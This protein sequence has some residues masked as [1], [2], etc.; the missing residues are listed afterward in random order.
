MHKLDF[1]ENGIKVVTKPMDHMESVSI[2][3][4]LRTGGRYEDKPING[5][6]HLL[7]HL[8]FKGTKTRDMKA[9]KEAIEGRGGSFNGFISEE[10]T[11]YLVK[12]LSKDAELG[13]DIL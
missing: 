11:C 6:S 4:W 5:I 8:L 10:F 9:I 12:V 3:I 7:E 13:I 2:G 1:L